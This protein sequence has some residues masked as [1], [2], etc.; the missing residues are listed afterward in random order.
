MVAMSELPTPF[1]VSRRV[2]F[3]TRKTSHPRLACDRKDAPGTERHFDVRY[4]GYSNR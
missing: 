3:V 2:D 4:V 1:V